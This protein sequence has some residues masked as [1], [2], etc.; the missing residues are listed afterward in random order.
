MLSLGMVGR[1]SHTL[2]IPQVQS[3]LTDFHQMY[4]LVDIYSQHHKIVFLVSL[5][6]MKFQK[7]IVNEEIGNPTKATG[8]IL[9]AENCF[10]FCLLANRDGSIRGIPPVNGST[11]ANGCKCG[12][13]VN[14]L[15]SLSVKR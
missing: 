6:K 13:H 4:R 3:D 7:E 10:R 15:W 8:L 11:I 14:F 12:G 1:I 2:R 9:P 5:D